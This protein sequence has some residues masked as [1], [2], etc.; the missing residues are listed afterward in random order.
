MWPIITFTTAEMQHPPSH[1]AHI[2]CL[3]FRKAQQ[4]PVNVSGCHFFLHGGIQW[5]TFASFALPCQTPLCQTAFLM[6][7]VALQEK[8]LEYWW[9]GSAIPLPSA[10]DVVVQQSKVGGITLRVLVYKDLKEGCKEV[11]ASIFSAALG[12]RKRG[13]SQNET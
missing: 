2:I 8:V 6:P 4:E 11:E 12:N 9:E 1:C 7:S 10:S 5:H 13:W 3:V